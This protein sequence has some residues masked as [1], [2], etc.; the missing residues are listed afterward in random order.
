VVEQSKPL[1]HVYTPIINPLEGE[2]HGKLESTWTTRSKNAARTLCGT[3]SCKAT[4]AWIVNTRLCWDLE[5]VHIR[6]IGEIKQIEDFAYQVQMHVLA[7]LER[8]GHS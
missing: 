8:L 6:Q 4:E 2:L 7:K 1:H 3:K 5:I